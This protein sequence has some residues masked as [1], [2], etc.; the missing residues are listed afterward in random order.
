[1][2]GTVLKDRNNPTFKQND[3]KFVAAIKVIIRKT[4]KEK[5]HNVILPSELTRELGGRDQRAN[6]SNYVFCFSRILLLLYHFSY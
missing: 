3:K 4:I 1:M 2:S 6:N 5:R